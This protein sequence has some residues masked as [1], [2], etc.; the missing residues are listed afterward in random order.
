MKIRKNL[1]AIIVIIMSIIGLTGCSD[2]A[3]SSAE[4]L[5]SNLVVLAQD[6]VK[7]N[8]KSP[9]TAK[10]P[11]GYDKYNIKEISSG[12]DDLKQY[13]ISSYVDAKN[14]FNAEIRN[15]FV[16]KLEITT[17]LKKYKILNVEI[18]NN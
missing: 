4:D 15:R 7:D 8:L 3:Q 13:V 17:D 18:M 16:V 12:K 9:S 11:W 5:T 14:S 10:F 1:F 6:A 2:D